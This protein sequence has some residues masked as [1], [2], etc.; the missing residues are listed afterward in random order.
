MNLGVMLK[1]SHLQWGSCLLASVRGNE[2]Q[3]V[4]LGAAPNSL[5]M[6]KQQQLACRK[7]KNGSEIECR[8]A[9]VWHDSPT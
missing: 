3:D 5:Q 8:N 7:E 6:G 9:G 4:D 1:K 2:M